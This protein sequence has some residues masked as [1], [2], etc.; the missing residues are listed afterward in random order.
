[1]LDVPSVVRRAG[2]PNDF[3][4]ARCGW[5][6]WRA[7]G[8]SDALH[9]AEGVH[10]GSHEARIRRRAY[11]LYEQRGRRDGHDMEDWLH[12]KEEEAAASWGYG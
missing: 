4:Y 9:V 7:C 8:R 5:C 2:K 11:E 6:D 12:A 10:R 1:M 3:S